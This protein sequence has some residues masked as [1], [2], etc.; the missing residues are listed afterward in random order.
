MHADIRKK[1]IFV[2]GEGPT[3]RLNDATA[4]E[5]AKYS[6]NSTRLR[7]NFCLRLYYNGSNRFLFVNFTY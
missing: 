1:D 6:I 4:T 3:N 5:E 7:K 2:L